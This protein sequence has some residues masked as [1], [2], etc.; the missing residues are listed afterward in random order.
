MKESIMNK[1]TTWAA[2]AIQKVSPSVQKE[3]KK[4]VSKSTTEVKDH[5]F[6]ILPIVVGAV[7]LLDGRTVKK[8][9]GFQA[10]T[11]A[12]PGM[13]FIYNQNTYNYYG[14]EKV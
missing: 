3:M 9:T 11:E 5:I 13:I 14:G 4:I 6:A 7:F 2:E 12:I 10:C 8:A 1:F